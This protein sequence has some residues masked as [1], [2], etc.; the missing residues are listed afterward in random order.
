MR[1]EPCL[2]AATDHLIDQLDDLPGTQ[3]THMKDVLA[4][5][6]EN[7]ATTFEVGLLAYTSILQRVD[8][9][10]ALLFYFGLFIFLALAPKVFRRG[11]P[12]ATGWWS[13][14]FPMAAL[15]IAALKYSMF[16]QAWPVK[17]IAIILLAMLSIAIAVLFVR[18]LHILLNG[19]LLAG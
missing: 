18:T 11:I 16:V 3:R 13:I 17:V 1:H 12:F 5:G 4:H 6:R 15:A 19:K 10:S 9:F 2:D 8:T 7:G 14:T